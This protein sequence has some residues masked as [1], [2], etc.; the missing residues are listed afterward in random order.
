MWLVLVVVCRFE[1]VGLAP[2]IELVTCFYFGLAACGGDVV[3]F[4][5]QQDFDVPSRIFVQFLGLAV[6]KDPVSRIRLPPAGSQ[7]V[8]FLRVIPFDSPA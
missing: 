7:K 3:G 4:E 6:Y 1:D 2:V 5:Q 8:C